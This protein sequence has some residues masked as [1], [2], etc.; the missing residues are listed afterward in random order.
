MGAVAHLS[1]AKDRNGRFSGY[2]KCSLCV[3]EFRPNPECLREMASFFAAHVR[4]SHPV[5][6]TT[7]GDVTQATR[8]IVKE[9]IE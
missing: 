5:Q 9:E 4:L 6:K 2:F 8:Q 7:P 1:A 3:A